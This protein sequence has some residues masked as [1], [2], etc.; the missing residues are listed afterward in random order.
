[1]H[2]TSTVNVQQENQDGWG[3]P[4]I[5]FLNIVYS[6]ARV[7]L[8]V[9]AI[10]S[11]N[12]GPQKWYDSDNE[13]QLWLDYFRNSAYSVETSE[14]CMGFNLCKT[15]YVTMRT[16]YRA[17]VCQICKN[18]TTTKWYIGEKFLELLGPLKDDY[19]AANDWVCKKGYWVTKV[20][21]ES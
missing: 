14:S 8:T 15:H 5:S 13:L 10:Q 21:W 17:R 20:Y 7:F 18:D 11:M 9:R 1:M 6:V 19:V 12:G 4:N 3:C 2:A 16:A